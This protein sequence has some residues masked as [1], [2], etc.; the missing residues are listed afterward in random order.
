MNNIIENQKKAGKARVD[1]QKTED[2][3]YLDQNRL[4][5][6]QEQLLLAKRLGKAGENEIYKLTAEIK[7]LEKRITKDKHLFESAKSNLFKTLS[8]F[9]SLDQ[10]QTL[11]EELD[12]R[13]P[14]LLLP[15][16]LETRFMAVDNGTELWV[17]VFPDDIAVFTHEKTLTQDELKAGMTYWQEMWAA[18]REEDDKKGRLEKEAW[19][20]LA[21]VYESNR[22]AWIASETKPG[23]LD[24]DDVGDF[25]FP[26]FEEEALKKDPWSR[27]PR[28]KVMPDRFVFMAFSHRKAVFKKIGNLIPNPLV[29]GPDPQSLEPEL[30]Q[31]EGD[32]RMG[33]N[34]EW[35]SNFDKAVEIGM[36]V[37]I[38]LE[39]PFAGNGFDRLLVL[40]LRLS[41]DAEETQQL[42]E[43]LIDNHHYAPEG[44]SF[45]PQGT[46]TN[47]T[48]RKGS[49]FSSREPGKETG[50]Q[51]ETGNANF[52]TTDTQTK[53]ADAQLLAESLGIDH[54]VLEYLQHAGIHDITE[55]Q[56]FN[57]ALWS[58]T[59]G[60]F[61]DEMMNFSP[62]TI[63]KTREFFTDFVYGRGPLP[64]IRVGAQPYGILPTTAFSRWQWSK[65]LEGP[66]VGFL[67]Q[68]SKVV[69][70][71]DEEWGRM[72]SRV[73]HV[74][75]AGDP[76]DNLLGML[77]LHSG[78]AEF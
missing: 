56:A 54:T 31:E 57:K 45:V 2:D 34:L 11:V 72:V 24:V 67:T 76:F 30:A 19:W 28:S 21:D 37:R 25:K 10:P 35:L 17:R 62:T 8:A 29:L 32:L 77:G 66:D 15:V 69:R 7:N 3:L 50:F 42:L 64:A 49:G 63:G 38:P 20:K 65:K 47:N 75:A 39:E 36:G 26:E 44:M 58:A 60:Y 9:P 5:A 23:T 41:S 27:A 71:I 52:E 70:R 14:F 33:E 4:K 43:G 48:D 46:P 55:A 1:L 53:K 78:S 74:G 13:L 40:G 59:L 22:A 68:L 61:M 6:K 16:R 12:D 18:S 51:V 73:P